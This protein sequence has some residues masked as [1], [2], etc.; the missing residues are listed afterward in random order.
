[1]AEAPQTESYP[2]NNRWTGEVQFISEIPTWLDWRLKIGA[3]VNWTFD[4]GA[5]LSDASL[6]GADLRYA[7]LSD[8]DLRDAS[9]RDADLRY[10]DLSDAS[11]RGADLRY[12]DLSD[13]DLRD[14]SLRGAALSSAVLSGADLSS[15]DLRGADL[16]GAVLSD[17]SLSD[18]P[19][20]PNLDAAILAAIEAGGGLDMSSWHHPCGTSHCRAGWAVVTAGEAGKELER[21]VGSEAA[22]TLIYLVSRPGQPVP[23]FYADNETTLAS[24]RADAGVSA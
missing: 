6:R 21:K 5:V 11:L 17:A 13:A 23:N 19:I 22:G 8:A 4:S 7:D 10:A 15:A 2:V 16:S 14:A 24:L 9:L 12:A 18:I 20:V 1:M 3:A